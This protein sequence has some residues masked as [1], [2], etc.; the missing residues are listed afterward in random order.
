MFNFFVH[1]SFSLFLSVTNEAN[2]VAHGRSKAMAAD[3]GG[4]GGKRATS[5]TTN[6]QPGGKGTG[7]QASRDLRMWNTWYTQ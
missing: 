2:E 1:A 7:K 6:L 5:L 3:G 4:G